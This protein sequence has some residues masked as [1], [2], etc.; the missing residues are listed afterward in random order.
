[1]N[2]K[3]DNLEAI[4]YVD[5][6]VKEYLLFRGFVAS[7][8]AFSTECRTDK[9]KGFQADKIVD[10]FFNFISAGDLTSLLDYWKYLDTRYFSR[11]EGRFAN[12]VKYFETCLLRCYLVHA[13][14]HKRADKI[15]EFFEL[16]GSELQGDAEWSKWFALPYLANPSSDPAFE[17]FFTKQW[18]DV[19]VLS[20]HNFLNTI[21]QNMVLP[22]LLSVTSDLLHRRSLLA[23]LAQLQSQISQLKVSS[24]PSEASSF[25]TTKSTER[26]HPSSQSRRRAASLVDSASPLKPKPASA[27]SGGGEKKA[28]PSSPTAK[29]IH[30]M[31]ERSAS[32]TPY[33]EEADLSDD[34][35]G[36]AEGDGRH[37]REKVI[38][39]LTVTRREEFL[40][41]T[42][43]IVDA[44]FSVDGDLIASTDSDNIVRVWSHSGTSAPLK[45]GGDGA[46]VTCIEWEARIRDRRFVFVGTDEGMVKMWSVEGRGVVWEFGGEEKYP[47]ITQVCSSPTEPLAL[48]CASS[49]SGKQYST[50]G[51][52]TI[53]AYNTKKPTPTRFCNLPNSAPITAMRF[54]HNGQLFVAGDA[55]GMM[56]VFDIRTFTPIMEWDITKCD[57]GGGGGGEGAMGGAVGGL[58]SVEF[59]FDENTVF[60]VSSNSGLLTR[61][62][63]HKPGECYA[64]LHLPDYAPPLPTSVLDTSCLGRRVAFS[65]DTDYVVYAS[66]GNAGSLLSVSREGEKPLKLSPHAQ[67]LS[68]VDWAPGTGVLL[69]GAIDGTIQV[70]QVTKT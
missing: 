50:P 22:K 31:Q 55:S 35:G 14:Q 40:E 4:Q 48:V 7:F 70:V 44:R 5:D 33:P 66:T 51:H 11:V 46:E 47:R 26:L 59:S 9:D 58:G 67:P 65:G 8:R 60:A 63:M 28:V 21:F 43:A 18:H 56:R 64:T 10:E 13:V 36:G 53:T 68:V 3:E 38:E 49:S 19:F 2:R 30:S 32:S 1:M 69:T 20:L 6:L 15:T 37:K 57:G 61:W 39:K 52:V 62:S 29:S 17:V 54:N 45:I 27:S 25:D 12:T 42:S 41:H 24:S 34:G 23:E 16:L